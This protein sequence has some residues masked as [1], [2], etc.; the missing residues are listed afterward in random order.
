V[1]VLTI[2]WGLVIRGTTLALEARRNG[3]SVPAALH[4]VVA[5]IGGSLFAA[6]LVFGLLIMMSKD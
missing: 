3:R 6:A 4:A 5:L 2:A 1:L